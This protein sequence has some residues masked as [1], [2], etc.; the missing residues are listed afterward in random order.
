LVEFLFGSRTSTTR[1]IATYACK[2]AASGIN[3]VILTTNCDLGV[4]SAF[5]EHGVHLKLADANWRWV[6]ENVID[7]RVGDEPRTA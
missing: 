2:L 5:A 6:K 3:V 1:G 7:G 4:K